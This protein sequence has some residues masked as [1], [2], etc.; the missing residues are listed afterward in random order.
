MQFCTQEGEFMKKILIGLFMALV[1]L[2]VAVRLWQAEWKSQGP[3]DMHF[4]P[5]NIPFTHQFDDKTMLPFSAAVV[6]D[7]DRDG[8]DDIFLG[9]GHGQQDILFVFKD[10]K[11]QALDT[12]IHKAPDD[13]SYGAAHIDIDAD[14]DIDLFIARQSG[15][16]L[17][18]N[19]GTGRFNGE[20]IK[21]F[22][23]ENSV[24]LSIALGDVNKD[25]YVDLYISGYIKKKLV[26]GQSIFKKAYGGYSQ[27]L[28]NNG[29]NTFT[30]KTKEAGLLRQHNTFTATFV[31]LDN[32]HDSD[33]VIAQDTGHI[34]M[35]E[36]TGTFPMK[37]INNPTVYSYPM[38]IAIGDYDNDGLVDIYAS[39]V[40]HTLPGFMLKGDLEK[41]DAFN[42]DYILL[43]NEGG[44]H[45]TDKAKDAGIARLG[46]GWGTVF[47]DMNL[48]GWPDL[49]VSQNYVKMPLNFLMLQYC[50]KVLQNN[51]NGTFTPVGKTANAEAKGFGITP[52]VADFNQDG[53]PDIVWV[54]INGQAKAFLSQ[55]KSQKGRVIR[56]KDDV[57]SLGALITYPMDDKTT[58]IRQ[59]VAGQGIG[60]DQTR[61]VFLPTQKP[62]AGN[63]TI[64]YQDG[65]VETL[66]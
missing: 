58:L 44:L 37:Q 32:D 66:P 30:D 28:V 41:T 24:P 8:V 65:T 15:V 63:I 6:L 52:L 54:N 56:L 2:T 18:L 9:G 12:D 31:D 10:G 7:A 45:F 51:G 11:F 55:H 42:P 36:N 61:S 57:R 47:A 22:M 14:G 27:L 38:G 16:W 19:D 64:T 21:P 49:L 50:G 25:G 13:A 60:S 34:E 5:A 43:H 23:A 29:D 59:I 39:N 35:Y 40:G 26:E 4:K 1:F 62:G 48:D 17:Y 3:T 46:F 33:L 53:W 20:R